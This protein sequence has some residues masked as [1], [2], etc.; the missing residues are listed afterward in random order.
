[1]SPSPHGWGQG[2]AVREQL[3]QEQEE[4]VMGRSAVAPP[5]F[6]FLEC[7]A[8]ACAS[9]WTSSRVVS[10]HP[11]PLPREPCTKVEGVDLGFFQAGPLYQCG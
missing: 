4:V 3:C 1:M 6:L 8:P 10:P 2:L 9:L 11:V 5:H 7:G